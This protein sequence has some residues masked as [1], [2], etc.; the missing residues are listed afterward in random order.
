MSDVPAEA[1]LDAYPPPIRSME[2]ELRAILREA[3]PDLIERVRGGWAL[4][5]Y[6]VPLGRRR[7]YVGFI[8]PEREHIH[9]GFE[10]GTLMRPRPELQGAHLGLRKVRFVTW[11][12][13]DTVDDAMSPGY[14]G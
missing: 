3:E 4:I 10:V 13:G 12:P 5:G 1:F 2:H 7:R 14:H 11:L 8:A 9:L 6:D